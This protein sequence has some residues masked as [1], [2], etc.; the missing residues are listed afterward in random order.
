MV[1]KQDK[2]YRAGI[3]LQY[4]YE[5]IINC[6]YLLHDVNVIQEKMAGKKV[7]RKKDIKK[8]YYNLPM[9]EQSQKVALLSCKRATNF[10]RV[11]PFS[12]KNESSIFQ[13]FMEQILEDPQID[14]IA[15]YFDDLPIGN[16]IKD[17]H[18]VEKNKVV[19]N[20]LYQ[21]RGSPNKC[22]WG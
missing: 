14:N 8:A 17:S 12:L 15:L 21:L 11:M 19:S 5:K 6:P 16:K 18:I 4:F 1:R 7:Y 9:S 13:R 3:D 10:F 2:N 20:L 22:E